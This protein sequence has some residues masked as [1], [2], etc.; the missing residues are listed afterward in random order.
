M[1]WLHEEGSERLCKFRFLYVVL[2][3]TYYSNR[4]LVANVKTQ[5]LSLD[6]AYT[7]NL[8]F[9]NLTTNTNSQ[10]YAPF[11]IKMEDDRRFRNSSVPHVREDGWATTELYQFINKKKE[12]SFRIDFLLEGH[13]EDSV[14]MYAIEGIE[15]RPV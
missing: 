13:R 7:M 12:N 15:F 9:K 11:K 2:M 14:R 5:F 3:G 6:I 1:N 10:I 8:V 4:H